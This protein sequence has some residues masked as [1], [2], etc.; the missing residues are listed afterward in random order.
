MYNSWEEFMPAW[1]GALRSG[2]YK[3]ARE[4]VRTTDNKFCCLGVA[5]DV[6]HKA[7]QCE[8]T[9]TGHGALPQFDG[10]TS[11]GGFLTNSES[12]TWL[13]DWMHRRVTGA[14]REAR[15]VYLNDEQK[16]DFIQIADW[17][18]QESAAD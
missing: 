11:V 3:Q 8:W 4:I 10:Q 2:E 6:L 12:P 13:R 1:V 5:A 18:E 9:P 17:I 15:L 7:G 16:Y 14:T